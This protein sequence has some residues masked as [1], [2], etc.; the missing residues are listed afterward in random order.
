MKKV[1]IF[2]IGTLV[3][4]GILT[5]GCS[6][7]AGERV[8][9][10]DSSNEIMLPGGRA[11]GDIPTVFDVKLTGLNSGSYQPSLIWT[12]KEYGIAWQDNQDGADQYAEIHFARID[13][14]GLITGSEVS[15]STD[16][17]YNS[18]VPSLA[19]SG[20][21]YGVAWL[22][23][24]NPGGLGELYYAQF[25]ST[26]TKL[27]QGGLTGMI[28]G[29]Q[30][31]YYYIVSRPGTFLTDW[32]AEGP[33]QLILRE[34]NASSDYNQKFR[35]LDPDNDGYYQI[36]SA[37]GERYA[38]A[39]VTA[40]GGIDTSKIEVVPGLGD[41]PSL[42]NWWAYDNDNNGTYLLRLRYHT[43]YRLYAGSATSLMLLANAGK[44]KF[45]K[46]VPAGYEVR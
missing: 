29:T 19:W 34:Y 13:A 8:G 2:S 31:G 32:D 27:A 21:A 7:P 6:F 46:I 24:R 35:L 1:F 20:T 43:S 10:A 9:G 37:L 14:G 25:D 30:D 18:R 33:S 15:I 12:G 17:G 39:K 23:Y 44:G 22:D 36:Q 42:Y 4:A 38:S 40:S 45:W 3:L 26:G 11:V 41:T 16:D 5:V 28:K